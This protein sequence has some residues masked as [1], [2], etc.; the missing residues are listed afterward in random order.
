MIDKATLRI[1]AECIT[2]CMKPLAIDAN[3]YMIRAK[4]L[5]AAYDATWARYKQLAAALR[6]IEAEMKQGRLFD[7]G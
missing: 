2:E 5:D 1:A 7:G 6:E 3:L 4:P